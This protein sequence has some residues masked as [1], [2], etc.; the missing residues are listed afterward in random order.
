MNPRQ[1]SVLV[2]AILIGVLNTSYLSLIN[3]L[4]CL[5]VIIGGIVTVQQFTKRAATGEG[6]PGIGAGDGA[7]LGALAGV[8]GAILG[9]LFN[10]LLRPLEL[11]SSS[12]TEDWIQDMM[13]NMQGQEGMSP[14]MMQQF[15]DGGGA[16]AIIFGLV[17][18]AVIFA[19]F[20]AIGG[21][22]GSAMF[23][24]EETA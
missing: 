9:A 6:V 16:M 11:D 2:G 15:Q 23:G 19:I 4:C 1:Q 21:A 3:Y 10:L 13:S 24:E 8:G 22:I 18:S 20:G 12:I 5:G 7:A 17:V 14:E